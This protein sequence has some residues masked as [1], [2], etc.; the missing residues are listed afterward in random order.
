M[1]VYMCGKCG[2]IYNSN[3]SHMVCVGKHP[4][5]NPGDN[6]PAWGPTYAFVCVSCF[7]GSTQEP[8][9]VT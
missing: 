8:E 5:L 4:V 1:N 6:E 7:A 3:N 9:P 2:K